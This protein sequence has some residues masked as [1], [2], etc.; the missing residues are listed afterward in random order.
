MAEP[1]QSIGVGNWKLM[2]DRLADGPQPAPHAEYWR[3]ELETNTPLVLVSISIGK[4]HRKTAEYA[5]LK[6]PKRK[7]LQTRDKG[8]STSWW[9][10][11]GGPYQGRLVR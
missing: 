2:L 6:M 7:W 3:R 10:S 9:K 4:D 1:T 5:I 8:L 11:R